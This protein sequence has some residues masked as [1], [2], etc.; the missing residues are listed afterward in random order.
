MSLS[1]IRR[2]VVSCQRCGR[3][4]AYCAR[5]AQERRAAFRDEDYWGRPLPGFGDPRARLL[6]VGLAPAAHGA[7]RTGRM[8]TG[9]RSGDFLLRAMHEAGL[10]NLPTS[11]H[12][13]DGLK[14]TA[15]YITAVVRCAPPENKPSPKEIRNCQPFLEAEL[16]ALAQVRVVV[17]L[18]KIA[19]DAY[20]RLAAAR[21]VTPRPRPP[22]AH[23]AVFQADGVPSLVTSYHP[24]QQNTNTGTLTA[25][26]LADV[27][28]KAKELAGIRKS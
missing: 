22:F 8:F 28:G 12:A 21:G 4:R 1:A 15:A 24:S 17:A 5:V 27:F 9:D 18:G 26:M 2:Q 23:G 13:K 25:S 10:A 6:I 14:L 20:W 7:N 11:Q 19:Y 16:T 3:L